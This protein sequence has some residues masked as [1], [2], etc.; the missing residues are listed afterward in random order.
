MPCA[1]NED[2]PRSSI[3]LHIPLKNYYTNHLARRIPPFLYYISETHWE[4]NSIIQQDVV[5]EAILAE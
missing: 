1:R 4:A 3:F 5:Y 2:K